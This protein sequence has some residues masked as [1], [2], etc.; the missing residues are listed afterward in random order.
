MKDWQEIRAI[1]KTEGDE[2]NKIF[3]DILLKKSTICEMCDNIFDYVPQ[4]RFCSQCLDERRKA[5]VK[6]YKYDT[7]ASVKRYYEKHKEK[8]L[9]RKRERYYE[10]KSSRLKQKREYYRRNRERILGYKKEYYRRK[11]EGEK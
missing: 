4:K 2:Y 5:R 9:K 3:N 7:S 6:N 1:E 10:N 11:K 8:I